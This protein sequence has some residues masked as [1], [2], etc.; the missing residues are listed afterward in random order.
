MQNSFETTKTQYDV[1]LFTCVTLFKNK[2]NDYGVSFR[3]LRPT[4]LTDQLYIK[5]ARL[6]QIQ[7]TG[8]AKINES[9]EESFIAIVNYALIGCIQLELPFTQNNDD[10]DPADAIA[11][12]DFYAKTI[13]ELMIQKNT[14]YGEAWRSMSI[15]S[16]TDLIMQKILRMRQIQE[17]NYKVTVSEPVQSSYFDIAN[18]AL[19]CLIKLNELDE[20]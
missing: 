6:R 1:V 2:L 5:A 3:V 8:E 19:F 15:N 20:A 14:D 17:N 11:K 9:A 13:K 12:Y 7:E 4:S 16:I 18:Y 10:L